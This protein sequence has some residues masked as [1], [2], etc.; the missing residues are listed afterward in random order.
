LPAQITRFCAA[1]GLSEANFKNAQIGSRA[2]AAD[3]PR[4]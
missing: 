2:V 4:H 3:R 1:T